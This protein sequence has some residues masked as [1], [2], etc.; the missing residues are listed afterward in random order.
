MMRYL[1]YLWNAVFAPIIVPLQHLDW[2]VLGIVA[3]L[4]ATYAIE[5]LRQYSRAVTFV[6]LCVAAYLFAA[7]VIQLG[8]IAFGESS[9][10]RAIYDHYRYDGR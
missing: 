7:Q 1:A 4:A 9:L 5:R 2:I 10:M 6:S 8:L 3:A